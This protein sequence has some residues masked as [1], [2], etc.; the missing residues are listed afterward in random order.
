[1]NKKQVLLLGATGLVGS[2]VLRELLASN[3]VGNVTVLVRKPLAISN[4]KLIQVVTDF[5]DLSALDSIGP[6][7]ALFCCIGTTRKKT[8][9][10]IQYKAIDYGITMAVATY[11][12]AHG[13]KQIHLV[14]SVGAN[15]KAS[16]FYLKIKGE[17]EEGIQALGVERCFIYRPSMLIGAR[18]ESRPAEKL[19]Q[20]LTPIFDVFTFGGQY[21]SIRAS[22]LAQCMVRQVERSTAGNQFLYYRDFNA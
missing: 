16:N 8:P 6:V 12:K 5:T 14:S 17:V 13:C 22:E 3:L 11:A 18:N 21:H 7:D 2:N 15:S 20:L 10:L 9:D 19:G 4:S 1:M